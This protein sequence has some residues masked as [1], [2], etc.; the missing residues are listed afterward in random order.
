MVKRVSATSAMA[1]L[2]EGLRALRSDLPFHQSGGCC[3]GSAPI[4]YP[5]GE[6]CIGP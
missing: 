6:F 5:V 2:I 1:T 3:D 4:C